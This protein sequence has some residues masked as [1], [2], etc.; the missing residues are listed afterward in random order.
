MGETERAEAIAHDLLDRAAGDARTEHFAYHFLA[1]CAL[2]RGDSEEAG[3]PLTAESAGRH[4]ARRP[5]R[6]EIRSAGCGDVGSRGG[7]S[8]ARARPRRIGRSA[9]WESLGVSFSIGF[10]DALPERYLAPASASLGD[11]YSAIRAEGRALPFDDAVE[12][13]LRDDTE[14]AS[15]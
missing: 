1:D 12:P 8:A 3:T 14:L 4:S 15:T 9:L 10:W 2:I 13:A 5:R 11:E 6:D 7:Q